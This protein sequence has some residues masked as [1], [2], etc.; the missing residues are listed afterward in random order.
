M[1]AK[2]TFDVERL[3][4]ALGD[5]TR[6]RLLNLIPINEASCEPSCEVC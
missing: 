1:A 5:N 6:L 4:Q 2:Q 3:F